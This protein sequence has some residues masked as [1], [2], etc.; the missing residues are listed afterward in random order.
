MERNI[1]VNAIAPGPF[2]SHML[3][4]AVNFDYSF[5]A[6]MNPRKELVRLKILLDY[7]FI[8]AQERELTVGETITCDGG[9]V[10]TT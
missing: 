1:V 10:N 4:K 5:I 2:D 9:M 7:A 3:G 6:D 8:F